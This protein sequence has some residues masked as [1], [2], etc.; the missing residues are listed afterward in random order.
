MTVRR[1][2]TRL[3][4]ALWMAACSRSQAPVTIGLAG[5]FSQAR[6]RSMRHGAQLAVDQI[7]ARGGIKGRLVVLRVA[8]D[9]A[10]DDAA[11]RVA[12]TFSND[13]NVVAVVGHLTSGASIAAAQIYGAR[14]IVMISPGASSVDLNGLNAYVF[15]L[16]PTDAAYGTALARYAW[17]AFGARRAAIIFVN[18]DYGRGVRKVFSS[19]FARLGGTVIEEDPYVP[20]T[21]TLE[22]YLTRIQRGGIDVLML[23]TERP[24]AEL[25][26]RQ[27]QSLGAS[28]HILGGDALTGIEAAGAIAEGL[29]VPAAYLPDRPGEQN[30]AFVAA[31]ARAFAGERPDQR[32]AASYDAVN[33]LAR[34]IEERGSSRR[35]VQDYLAQIGR[36]EPAFEGITGRITFDSTGNV[37][38]KAVVMGVVRNGHLVS[39]TSP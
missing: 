38:S 32:G 14:S 5:P 21:P 26:L 7:N 35:G 29:R 19:A 16:C 6:G 34:A 1:I 23:A 25:A 28:W 37:P 31:Y 30:A 18:D 13:P 33:L 4:A 12:E 3:G 10:D 20:T 36:N 11:V 2:I 24:G 8:D 39:E 22:P 27:M 15:R 17:Q 9:S